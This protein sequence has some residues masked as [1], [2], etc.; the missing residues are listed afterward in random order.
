[1]FDWFAA[2]P[3]RPEEPAGDRP[4]IPLTS[5]ERA[6]F[7]SLSGQLERRRRAPSLSA[8][9]RWMGELGTLP[10]GLALVVAGGV[11]CIAWLTVSVLLSF[12]GVVIQAVGL[13]LVIDYQ[14]L[15]TQRAGAAVP[16]EASQ[17]QP[18]A[19]RRRGL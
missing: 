5:D 19:Q 14:R 2:R 15:R 6:A 16:P 12:A 9:S 11:W 13:W 3:P 17:Q 4:T 18:H 10:A 7:D 8:L 1:M